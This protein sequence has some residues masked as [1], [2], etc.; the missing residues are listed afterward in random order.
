MSKY[1]DASLI[2]PI[3]PNYKAGKIYSLKPTNGSGDFTVA[4]NQIRDAYNS[5]GVSVPYAVNVPRFDWRADYV[6]PTDSSYY[7]FDGVNDYIT[8]PNPTVSPVTNPFSVIVKFKTGADITTTQVLYSNRFTASNELAIGISSGNLSFSTYNG[9]Y[10]N[11]GYAL[12]VNTEYTFAVTKDSTNTQKN[13]YLNGVLVSTI[14][15]ASIAAG[16]ALGQKIGSNTTPSSYFLG[17]IYTCETYNVELTASE[18]L[19]RY[20]GL[21]ISDAYKGATNVERATNGSFATDTNWT[22]D[23]SWTISA[24][25]ANV[26]NA[27]GSSKNIYQACLK[28]GILYKVTYT[29]SNYVSGSIVPILTAANGTTRTANGT[30]TD[31][32]TSTGT[33]L[34]FNAANGTNLSIDNVSVVRAGNTLN[35]SKG[36]TTSLWYDLDHPIQGTIIGAALANTNGFGSNE[37]GVDTC[38]SV[39]TEPAT[40]MYFL[41]SRTPV[42]QTITTVVGT[43]YTINCQGAG[44]ITIE[45]N[46]GAILGGTATEID[47]FTY[48]ASHTSVDITLSAGNSFDWVQMSDS[49]YPLRHTETAGVTLAC[50]ADAITGGGD[51]TVFNSLEGVFY[52][53]TASLSDNLQQGSISISDGTTANR[54][55]IFPT[56]TSINALVVVNSVTILNTSFSI[57][58][59]MDF[60]KYAVRWAVS[61][62]S[63]WVNGVNVGEVLSGATFASNTLNEVRFSDTSTN[64]IE[65]R[66]KGIEVL[67]YQ[68]DAQMATLTTL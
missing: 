40:T 59:I 54:I 53:D 63:F 6:E 23:T 11:E 25:T 26:N 2:L 5:L 19:D 3:A 61:D 52:V 42:S 57:S 10:S 20:N 44:V 46:G 56:T 34:Y 28:S 24:G 14:S 60:N 38:P 48:T 8:L 9:S 64:Y 27:T 43:N 1:S 21:V 37:F 45:E 62:F 30:Y 49:A 13:I 35:L 41:N 51:A 36:K 12:S 18:V 4:R 68:T 39:L 16:S 32:V 15:S 50:I 29:I 22:K 31:Y 58:N 65:V 66:V 47:H 67:S 17:K 7:S 33:I 55:E